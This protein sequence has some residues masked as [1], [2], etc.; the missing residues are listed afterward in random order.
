MNIKVAVI[1]VP[2]LV[3][4]AAILALQQASDVVDGYRPSGCW[5]WA[6]GDAVCSRQKLRAEESLCRRHHSGD[7]TEQGNFGLDL[8][9]HVRTLCDPYFLGEE[10]FAARG[11]N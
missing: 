3:L 4:P 5:A 1:A 6:W 9:K 11:A 2:L 7:Y 8:P 10:Y